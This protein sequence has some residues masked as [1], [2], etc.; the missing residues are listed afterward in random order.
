MGNVESSSSP[1]CG[2]RLFLLP[3]QDA[4]LVVKVVED[5]PSEITFDTWPLEE[6]KSATTKAASTGRSIHHHN[7]QKSTASHAKCTE[8]MTGLQ[9]LPKPHETKTQSSSSSSLE[10]ELT[11][12]QERI[13]HLERLRE[14]DQHLVRTLN[15]KLKHLLRSQAEYLSVQHQAADGHSALDRDRA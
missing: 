5:D 8:T 7:S 2:P 12:A 9:T 13:R 6:E 1:G 15:V 11:L 3:R 10:T 4:S 14:A